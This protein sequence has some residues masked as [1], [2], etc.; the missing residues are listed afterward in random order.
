MGFQIDV[1]V[2]AA[3]VFVQ[4]LL[5]FFSPCVLP[6]LPL[7]L[8][9]LSGGAGNG[10]R[11]RVFLNTLCFVLGVSFAI[12]LL[13][14]GLSFI[15]GLFDRVLFARIGGVLLILFGLYQLGAF[16]SSRLLSVERRLPLRLDRLAMS[17][18]TALLM[19]FAFS[20]AWTPC[21]GPVLS[22]VLLMAASAASRQT[23][24]LLL[25]VYT[26][27]FCLPFLALGLFTTELLEKLRAHRGVV[28][29]TVKVGGALLILMGVMM[30]T[31]WMNSVTGYLSRAAGSDAAVTE[32]A[33]A[34][35]GE[36]ETAETPEAAEDAGAVAAPDFTLTDQYGVEH[37][38]SDYRGKVVFLNF[39]ATWC[40]P[41]RAEMPDIQALYEAYG[42][43]A[44]AEVLILA[45]ATPGVGG[46][47]DEAGV[48]AFL[49]ENGYTYP[50]VMD[51]TGDI[52]YDYGISAFPTTFM[53]DTAGNVFGYVP[54]AMSEEVMRGIIEQTIAGV[55]S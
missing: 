37:T 9:Y 40:P 33:P 47:A 54:G 14:M 15:G 44:D 5:S 11:K 30:L 43:A 8:G 55:R 19:G 22:G 50:V 53:I 20:F 48:T 25:G 2:S 3:T 49:E 1:G 6:L 16:G 21:V 18:W 29:Y 45:V 27:G 52:L 36:P 12:F 35:A 4:G 42:D 13:G 39:W 23:G 7:Y 34:Q 46:E 10:E 51:P 17:P 31:G 24:V 38:L 41:C 28:K 32:S 26:L